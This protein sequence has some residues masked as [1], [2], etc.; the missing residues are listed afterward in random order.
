MKNLRA[1]RSKDPALADLL[2]YAAVIDNGIIIL[3]NGALMASWSYK[4][5]DSASLTFDELENRS[6]QVNNALQRLGSGWMTQHDVFR[7][8][9]KSYPDKSSCH[10]PDPVTEMMDEERRVV[11]QSGIHHENFQVVTLT[12][13]PPSIH[14]SRTT[15]LMVEGEDAF[16]LKGIGRKNI[17]YFINACREF[18]TSMSAVC[19]MT[20]LKGEPTVVDIHGTEEIHDD[21]L[22]FIHR[23]I[24][25]NDHPISLPPVAMYLDRV[26]GG[27]D[28][29]SGLIPVIGGKY[30]GVVCMDGFPQSSFPGILEGLDQLQFEY[31]WNNRFIYEDPFE[32]IKSL[33]KFRRQWQQ[34]KRGFVAQ[35]I[36]NYNAPVD[37]YA[38]QMEADTEDSI[39]EA[40]SGVVLFGYY[41]ST[42]VLFGRDQDEMKSGCEA[43]Q[44]LINNLGFNGR[45]ET[46]N[47]NEAYL[48]SLPGHSSENIRRPVIHTL[49]LADF[50]P[51]N[52][53]WPG[54]EFCPN[55]YYPSNSPPLL[56]ASTT[57]NTPFRLNLHVQDLGHALILGPTGAG[58]STLLAMLAAQFRKYREATVFVFEKGYSFYPLCSAIK[59]SH[60]DIGGENTLDFCPL[61]ELKTDSEQ[62]WAEV[63]ILNALK[64]QNVQITPKKRAAVTAALHQHRLSS[65]KSLHD[66][67]VNLQDNEMSL[68]LERYTVNDHQNAAILDA[69]EDTFETGSFNVFELESLMEMG[70]D[71]VLPVLTYIFHKIEKKLHGQPAVIFLDEAWIALGHEVFR[72]KI[73]E[74]LKTLRKCNCAVVMSTQSIS[75]ASNSGI[76]DVINESCPTKIFL[77]NA[78]AKDDSSSKLYSRLG[79]NE[80]EIDL[81]SKAIPKREYYFRN[82]EGRRLFNLQ[83][84]PVAM[85]LAGAT[86]KEDIA[87]VREL[88][89]SFG[90]NWL[91]QWFY[92]K[93][94]TV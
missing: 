30:I 5:Q 49:N 27:Q 64:L 37:K 38:Q 52:S 63:W 72:N 94:V 44:S 66:F 68:A 41:T 45:I 69:E 31:R 32:A 2:N 20:R 6:S 36:R 19:Q 71:M 43:V 29:L 4:G 80:R 59:G 9:S 62:A 40:S 83:L 91:N 55:P 61:G 92:E 85:A 26:I 48:G 58:K 54:R 87:R 46:I 39:S 88:R 76:L 8:K 34:K 79:L 13:L 14:K 35:L 75:D 1:Y 65:D 22:R 77:P 11:Y 33:H 21:Q 82:P 23:C 47:A 10:F 81:L 51:L 86:G 73:R 60:F 7:T 16:N 42:I 24:T 90:E 89:K 56:H 12:Y 17:S 3:K 70:E 84:G 50:L 74:W 28:Y 93:G 78:V 53:I 57:G 18:E 67:V 25:G 15:A